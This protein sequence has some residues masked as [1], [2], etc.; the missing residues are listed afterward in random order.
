MNKPS[1]RDKI[2]KMAAKVFAEKTF[3]GARIDEIAKAADIPKSL[4]YYHFKSKEEI[5]DVLLSQF[6]SEYMQLLETSHKTSTLS[7]TH[8][9]NSQ[10]LGDKLQNIYYD[11]GR[12]NE[13][14]IRLI[15]IDA[16][17]KKGGNTVLFKMIDLITQLEAP[18]T[19]A[20]LHERQ[21]AEFFTSFLPCCAYICFTDSFTD[22]F[23]INRD[24]FDALFLKIYQETHGAY[25]QKHASK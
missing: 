12:Q 14:L 3:E 23:H 4:I 16:L 11:F 20:L 24:T 5:L 18:K 15:L 13:D 6:I 22:Y 2:L 1:A 17:K 19:E 21:V 10:L 9:T 25:H 7:H 8:N